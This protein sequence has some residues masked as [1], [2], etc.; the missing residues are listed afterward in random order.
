MTAFDV[1][2]T[3][4]HNSAIISSIGLPVGLVNGLG[5]LTGQC[6]CLELG[7]LCVKVLTYFNILSVHTAIIGFFN[8]LAPT[9]G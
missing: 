5:Y 4:F 3:K 7:L 8:D 6:F 1:V 9:A 2:V